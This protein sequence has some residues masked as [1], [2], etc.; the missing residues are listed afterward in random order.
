MVYQKSFKTTPTI[1]TNKYGLSYSFIT[2]PIQT[3][4]HRH[5][6][7]YGLLEPFIIIIIIIDIQTHG[8][9]FPTLRIILSSPKHIQEKGLHPFFHHPFGL[10][11][12]QKKKKESKMKRNRKGFLFLQTV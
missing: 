3:N 10:G 8:L 6:H 12:F 11:V 5:K 7:K 4:K 1:Q 2:I 9:S